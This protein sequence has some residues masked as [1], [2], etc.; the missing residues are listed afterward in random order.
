LKQ[1]RIP[2]AIRIERYK[3]AFQFFL[4]LTASIICGVCLTKI[5]SEG[6]RSNAYEKII[7][8]FI[9]AKIPR[10]FFEYFVDYIK[11]SSMDILI[12]LGIFIF[13]F[14]F[15]NYVVTDILIVFIGM[16]FGFGAFLL[17]STLNVSF[18]DKMA[19]YIFKI[20]IIVMM[21]V[22]SYMMAVYS[23]EIR[24]FSS[25]GRLINSKRKLGSMIICFVTFIGLILISNGLYCLCIYF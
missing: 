6:L 19:F 23:L 8:H 21:F 17:S 13:S 14:S 16:R 5:L 18:T 7:R 10:T 15:I 22:F 25:N 2:K 3:I 20:I 1:V 24:R 11:M 4:M 9:S 12:I